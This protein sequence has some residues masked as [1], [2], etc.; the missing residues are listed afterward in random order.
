M[1]DNTKKNW[2]RYPV[3]YFQARPRDI[4]EHDE[5][6]VGVEYPGQIPRS[7]G[8]RLEDVYVTTEQLYHYDLFNQ[9]CLRQMFVLFS[10]M[11]QDAWLEQLSAALDDARMD[12]IREEEARMED[13]Q[14][15]FAEKMRK[16][17]KKQ[18]GRQ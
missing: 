1:S 5:W 8:N 17:K 16:I 14:R 10:P 13:Y 15:Q 12:V 9:Q 4:D 11:T 2:P 7:E 3:I 18:E 6:M